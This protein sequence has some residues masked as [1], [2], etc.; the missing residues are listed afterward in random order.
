MGLSKLS[1]SG[2]LFTLPPLGGVNCKLLTPNSQVFGEKPSPPVSTSPEGT[3]TLPFK[4][5]PLCLV[6]G[7]F[8]LA[9]WIEAQAQARGS[10]EAERLRLVT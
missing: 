9:G 3:A 1:K 8:F 7:S 6:E 5:A 2:L 4:N 10:N